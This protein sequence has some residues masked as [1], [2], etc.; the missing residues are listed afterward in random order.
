MILKNSNHLCP[1]FYQKNLEC[2]LKNISWF[3]CKKCNLI[4]SVKNKTLPEFQNIIKEY[5]DIFKESNSFEHRSIQNF[6]SKFI[7]EKKYFLD[8]GCGSG[9]DL[10]IAKEFFDH[11]IGYEPNYEL[12]KIAKNK[13]LEVMN[14]ENCFNE[15][16]K[17]NAIF[18]RNVFRFLDDFRIKL[19]MINNSLKNDGIFIWRDKFFDYYPIN[20]NDKKNSILTSNYLQKKT[21]LFH[22][23]N[24]NFNILFKKFYFDDSFLIIAS[25]NSLKL[26]NK[27]LP[28]ISLVDSFN[29]YYLIFRLK[30]IWF[31]NII[32]LQRLVIIKII[33]K[34]KLKIN[35]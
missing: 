12:Y 21:I 35:S 6:I 31:Q 32:N 19:E 25:K 13:N 7:K 22:L 14:D 26:K 27:K 18:S 28:K 4:Y 20:L 30:N 1:E 23:K 10:N 5:F 9:N 17:F 34:L 15:K 11:V 2:K 24:A 29:F 8:Y 33:M 16:N 3:I